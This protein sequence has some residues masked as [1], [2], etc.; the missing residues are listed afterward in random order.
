MTAEMAYS[1]VFWLNSFPNQSGISKS[2]S[3][4]RM[5][6]GKDISNKRHCTLAFR[7]YTQVHEKHN[8]DMAIQT[9]GAIALRPTGN[10]QGGHYFLV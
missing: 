8:N 5:V 6:T 4:R 9:T 1:A 2:I 7:S 10:T 3:P